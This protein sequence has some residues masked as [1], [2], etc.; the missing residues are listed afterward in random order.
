MIWNKLKYLAVFAL[1]TAAAIG[2]GVGRWGT[3]TA[4]TDDRK[5][6]PTSAG[7]AKPSLLA[8]R[9][10]DA[11]AA[12]KQEKELAPR[13]DDNRPAAQGK[14]REAIIRLPVGTYTKDVEVA[15]Y[16][17]ARV[18]WTYEDDRVLGSI[19]A[20][21][22][23]FELEINTEAEFSLSSNGTIYGLLTG[24]KIVHLKFPMEGQFADAEFAQIANMWPLVEPLVAE[25]LTDMPF[26]YQFRV[27]G[28][29]LVISSYRALLAGPN[30]LGKLGGLVADN[31]Q[32][33]GHVLAAFQGFGMAMEGTYTLVDGKEA[34][35][36]KKKPRLKSNMGPTKMPN[37]FRDRTP[38]TSV[39]GYQSSNIV[40]EPLL[41][42]NLVGSGVPAGV[43]LPVMPMA[44]RR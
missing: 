29:R 26:S 12:Q 33:I 31:T 36:P 27:Q 2:F 38:A 22:M 28:N 35:Q 41:P 14:R 4:S 42:N 1:L 11:P 44:E 17:S 20:S 23:G 30:P 9:D 34:E 10:K 3:A 13:A 21:A 40:G 7:T 18:T 16:G 39:S 32:G 8:A 15:P 6:G 43:G 24:F 19:E 25:F 5:D 37:F